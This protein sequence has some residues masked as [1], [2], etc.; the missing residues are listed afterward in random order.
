MAGVVWVVEVAAK[1]GVVEVAGVVGVVAGK[2]TAARL[3]GVGERGQRGG[4]HAGREG[5]HGA[6]RQLHELLDPR[7]RRQLRTHIPPYT[8]HHRVL[9]FL[10]T[11]ILKARVN[12]SP[13]IIKEF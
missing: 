11:S 4:Q 2:D 3:V 9:L 5:Q 6:P 10:L 7:D 13:M 12:K 8:P 1:V